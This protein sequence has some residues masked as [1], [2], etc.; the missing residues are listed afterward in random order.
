MLPTAMAAEPNPLKDATYDNTAPLQL[1]PTCAK[2]VKVYDGDTV[3]LAFP[4]GDEIIRCSARMLG[5][6]TAEVR[7]R[8]VV[9][10]T[11]ATGARDELRNLILGKVVRCSVQGGT[12]KYGRLLAELWLGD[13]EVSVN[14]KVL[15]RW[16]VA[17][18]GGTKKKDMDWS[19]VPRAGTEALGELGELGDAALADAA[20]RT[21]V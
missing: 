9:E 19:L 5:Y 18:D 4:H 14:Q 21:R 15:D 16:G 7:T 1:T 10:K 17:Y 2:V 11:A 6:D 8:D 3:W 12:D 13:G 20:D